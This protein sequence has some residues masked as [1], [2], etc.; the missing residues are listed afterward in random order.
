MIVKTLMIKTL[1][2]IYDLNGNKPKALTSFGLARNLTYSIPQSKHC[3]L[4]HQFKMINTEVWILFSRLLVLNS[5][6]WKNKGCSVCSLISNQGSQLRLST[7]GNCYYPPEEFVC[8]IRNTF[9]PNNSA[10]SKQGKT[11]S[12]F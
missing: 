3:Y 8:L 5:F 4:L 7:I 6:E 11:F 9:L 2:S 10:S 12:K 1:Y